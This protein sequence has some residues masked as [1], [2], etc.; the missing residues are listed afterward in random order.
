[1]E[2][3]GLNHTWVGDLQCILVDPSGT[4]HNIFL[5]PGDYVFL[6]ATG[7]EKVYVLGAVANPTVVPYSSR[8]TLVSA[9][10][11]ARGP[12]PEAFTK[13]L[14]LVR[15]SFHK[16]RVAAVD[17]RDIVLGRSPNFR[18]QPGDIVWVPRKPWNKLE[19]YTR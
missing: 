3:L 13:G 15:G 6:P 9:I 19:E 2:I 4:A 17:L 7:R 16:P 18:L 1:M 5:R 8:V 12:V 11:A 10:A 14:V